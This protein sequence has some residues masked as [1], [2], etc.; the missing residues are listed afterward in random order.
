[1]AT[2][3]ETL[4]KKLGSEEAYRQ[5]MRDIRKRVQHHPGGS[6]KDKKFA[7]AMSQKGLNARWNKIHP[8]G[9]GATQE[10]QP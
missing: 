10:E 8:A 3:K 6:F 4:I 2:A 9:V 5:H 7:R 1:M